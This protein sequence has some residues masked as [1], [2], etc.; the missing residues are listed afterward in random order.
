MTREIKKPTR[1]SATEYC[2]L[3]TANS[4]TSAAFFFSVS[5]ASL[6]VTFYFLPATAGGARLIGV[7]TPREGEQHDIRVEKQRPALYVVEVEADAFRQVGVAAPAVDGGPTGHAGFHGVADVVVGDAVLEVFDEFG[8]LGTRTDQ[9]HVAF[10]HVPELREFVDVPLA[11]EGA[12]FEAASVPLPRPL[13]SVFIFGIHPHAAD[14]VDLEVFPA[15]PD[16]H[17]RVEDGAGGFC[18]HDGG[19]EGNQWSRDEQAEG[20]TDQVEGPLGDAVGQA[21]ERELSERKHGHAADGF[22]VESGNEHFKE[23]GD[24]HEAHH[25]AVAGLHHVGKHGGRNIR[26]GQEHGIVIALGQDVLEVGERAEDGQ[27]GRRLA[28][29]VGSVDRHG[30]GDD[31]FAE[32]ALARAAPE[33]LG[34]FGPS[35]D[36]ESVLHMEKQP[37][38]LDPAIESDP[39]SGQHDESQHAGQHDE[40]AGDGGFDFEEQAEEQVAQRP[41]HAC[42]EEIPEDKPRPQ[43]RVARINAERRPDDDKENRPEKE[44]IEILRESLGR[45]LSDECRLRQDPVEDPRLKSQPKRCDLHGEKEQGVARDGGETQGVPDGRITGSPGAVWLE[46]PRRGRRSNETRSLSGG[47]QDTA[48][49]RVRGV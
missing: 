28:H 25:F 27:F 12:D 29:E 39:P 17:L 9:A 14:L 48:F 26:V 5:S 35:D 46:Q 34:V 20:R 45:V 6:P 37:L 19:K 10:E 32:V 31:E 49:L 43:I 24:G 11:H 4:H 30:A 3:T 2:K 23:G 47:G 1:R 18:A 36:Q 44:V 38:F 41:S 42:L 7:L 22:E 8:A 33:G 15:A 40:G 21:V 16:A 13:R